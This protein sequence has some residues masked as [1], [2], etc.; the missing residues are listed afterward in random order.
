MNKKLICK[1][2][3][4]GLTI[5]FYKDTT[6]HS[7]FI[8]L[9]V[10]YGAFYSDFISNGQS[11]HIR[12]GM[13]HL[14]EHLVFEKNKFGN[15]AKLFGSKQMQTNA[16]TSTYITEFYVD[17][18]EDVDFALEHLLKGIS[19]PVFTSEDIDETKPPIYQEIRM[20]NDE[21]SR[22]IYKSQTKNMLRN[23]SYIDGLGSIEDVA[24]FTYDSVRLCYDI[25][26]QPKNEVLFMAGNFEIEEVLKKIE[27][28]YSSLPIQECSFS[29]PKIEEPKEVECHYNEIKM[30]TPKTHI[31]VCYKIDFS[32]YREEERRMLTYYI[33]IFLEMN[34]SIISPLYKELLEKKVIDSSLGYTFDFFENYMLLSVFGY[35][36]DEEVLIKRVREV[37]EKEHIFK[38]EIFDLDLKHEK[39]CHLCSDISLY[40]LSRQFKENYSYYHYAGFDIAEDLNKLNFQ[41]FKT[42]IEDLEFK[43]YLVTKITDN[44][45]E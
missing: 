27:E 15:F 1:T 7:V 6:K 11:Y 35:S 3:S 24:S 5:Y 10:K 41:D 37:L 22:N 12:D 9:M 33:G 34:F 17:T 30:P 40:G 38:E 23:Y 39:M 44:E 8:D 21:I 43:E 14:L 13:A 31:S 28:I 45:V 25:F 18:V 16:M 36:N 20:R 26:Y 2:L 32:K 29:L 19:I 4:N 42:F